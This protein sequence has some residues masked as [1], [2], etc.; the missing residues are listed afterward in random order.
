M[1]KNV[2][3]FTLLASVA[4][5]F[6]VISCK[7]PS[8][9]EN[10]DPSA[11]NLELAYEALTI[12]TRIAGD[13]ITLPSKVSIYDDV[14]VTWESDNPDI[15]TISSGSETAA[16]TRK[17]GTGED[18]VKLTATLKDQENNVKEKEFTVTVLQKDKS[19]S[20][21]EI[22]ELAA[23]EFKA[24]FTVPDKAWEK[25]SVPE[26]LT[27]QNK[28]V[29]VQVST[30]DVEVTNKGDFIIQKNIVVTRP[31]FTGILTLGN[32]S[33]TCKVTL[34][35]PAITRFESKK[36][37]TYNYYNNNVDGQ[38]EITYTTI[39]TLDPKSNKFEGLEERKTVIYAGNDVVQEESYT[40]GIRGTYTVDESN[41]EITLSYTEVYT[42][43]PSEGKFAW[44]TKAEMVQEVSKTYRDVFD[45]FKAYEEA[46][47][48]TLD[49]AYAAYSIMQTFGGKVLTK[50]EFLKDFGFASEEAF[51]NSTEDEKTA[52]FAKIS[53]DIN[54]LKGT[55]IYLFLGIPLDSTWEEIYAS[56]DSSFNEYMDDYFLT[57]VDCSYVITCYSES[58]IDIY[59]ELATI[60]AYPKYDSSKTW[61]KQHGS[62]SSFSNDSFIERDESRLYFDRTSYRYGDWN[63]SY[64]QYTTTD[65]NGDEKVF[66]VTDNKDGS[67]ELSDGLKSVTLYFNPIDVFGFDED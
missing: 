63:E 31:E 54:E 53:K 9:S 47:P 44:M 25:L 61:N 29:N 34:E 14:S 41:K 46:D 22:L 28:T 58:Q 6:T 24:L 36:T 55:L 4:M 17:D 50:E 57:D 18:L 23:E 38:E 3:I 16:V 49:T 37:E 51:I 30:S 1:K 12:Q 20:D 11:S 64:T 15:I 33:K 52:F 42:N 67:I 19:L 59:P 65:D 27:V 21:E 40:D 13:S 2:K 10:D 48:K 35:L 39:L 8:S 26:T 32:T 5:L 7:D 66:T 60:S 56:L 62:Y 45:A 43:K